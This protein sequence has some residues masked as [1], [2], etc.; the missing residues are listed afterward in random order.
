MIFQDS[1]F[2]FFLLIWSYFYLIFNAHVNYLAEHKRMWVS[3][4]IF[5]F[6]TYLFERG[7]KSNRSSGQDLHSETNIVIG[8]SVRGP[9]AC[10][11]PLPMAVAQEG[12]KMSRGNLLCLTTRLTNSLPPL[13]AQSLQPSG[14]QIVQSCTQQAPL[15]PLWVRQSAEGLLLLSGARGE[16]T[17]THSVKSSRHK[18]RLV[19]KGVCGLGVQTRPRLVTTLEDKEKL[20]ECVGKCL[21]WWQ[22]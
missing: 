5:F 21:Q 7:R 22:I 6:F 10:L 11:W 14:P 16:C 12:I 4:L 18:G 17:H 2:F 8:D 13:P 1:K 19:F 3:A 15:P 9:L 20:C